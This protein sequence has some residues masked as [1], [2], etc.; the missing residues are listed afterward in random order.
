VPVDRTSGSR[1]PNT[2]LLALLSV[3]TALVASLGATVLALTGHDAFATTV[4]AIGLSAGA[5]GGVHVT[6]NIRR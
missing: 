3:T 5:V 6:V 1:D 2:R 4:A